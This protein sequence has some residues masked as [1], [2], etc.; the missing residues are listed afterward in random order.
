[1]PAAAIYLLSRTLSSVDFFATG[2]PG[3]LVLGRLLL[4][5]DVPWPGP[6]LLLRLS[7]SGLEPLSPVKEGLVPAFLSPCP[8]RD[9][10]VLFR[11]DEDPLLP[12]FFGAPG[13]L[14]VLIIN[15][16]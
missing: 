2:R 11:G 5:D 9:E 16:C 1:M 3:F 13:L 15:Y 4:M 12:P 6:F 8:S 7:S 10:A 14:K